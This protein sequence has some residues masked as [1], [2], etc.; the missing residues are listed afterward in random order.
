MGVLQM[1]TLVKIARSYVGKIITRSTLYGLTTWLGVSA[2]NASDTA[3]VFGEGAA[4]LLCAVAA[5]LVDKWHV[6]Q[7]TKT[8]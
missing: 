7:D 1:D 4:A 8:E 6:G 2:A 3:T 5:A